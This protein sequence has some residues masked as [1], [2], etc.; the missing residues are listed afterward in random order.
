M[1]ELAG[2]ISRGRDMVVTLM[3]TL[4]LEIP[5]LL[6]HEK[7]YM[8]IGM[9]STSSLVAFVRVGWPKVFRINGWVYFWVPFLEAF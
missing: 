1:E 4:G 7:F 8:N 2:E 9:K 5:I 3:K 6:T